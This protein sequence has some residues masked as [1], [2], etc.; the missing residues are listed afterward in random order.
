MDVEVKQSAIPGAGRGLFATKDFNPGDIVLSLDRPYVAEL[1]IDRLCDTCAWC[2]QRGA[3]AEEERKN[4]AALGLPAGFVQ[5]KACTGCK[6]VRYCSKTC[7]SKAW[8]REHKYECKALSVEGRPDLPHGVRA[9]IKLLGKLKADPENKDARLIDILQFQPVT[10]GLEDFSKKAPKRFEDFGM[11]AYGAWKYA[12]EPKLG[13]MD[14]E[15]I[16][17]GLFFNVMCNTLQLSSPLDDTK[18]GIGF[19][20]VLCSANHSCDPNTAAI[21]NQPRQLLRALRPIKKGEEITMKYVDIT[22]PFSVRQAELSEAYFF[23]CKC[24]RCKKGAVWP[25]DKFLKP[26]EELAEPFLSTADNL[27]KRH[28]SQIAKFFIPANDPTAQRRV[29][30]IQAEAFSVSGITF[31]ANKGNIAASEDEIKDALKLT[32]NSGLWPVTRQPVPHLLRQ[33]LIL[34]LAEGRTYQAWRIALKIRFEISPVL[35]PQAFYPDRVIDCWFLATLSNQLCNPMIPGHKEIFQES[36]QNGL[37][38]RIVYMGFLCETRD[39][40]DKSY[41]ED[42]PFGRVVETM[43]AQTFANSDISEAELRN[44][45]EQTWPMLEA[46]A[47]SVDVVNL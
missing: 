19:D 17:K 38:L 8:K 33:R 24:I 21:F 28:Q 47:K 13:D 5:T 34:Y 23:G 39:A 41:G 9:V 11:L 43:Y 44:R 22:N 18:L 37:D 40:M 25:E 45:V 36:M 6:K 20:P 2:F 3:T 1:D 10:T 30:A 15:T 29:A 4:S 42:S 26:A 32:L 7:Q 35:H 16:A 27:I 12:G 46:V 14:T 31:D